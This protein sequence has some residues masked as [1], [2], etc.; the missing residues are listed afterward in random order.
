M[1]KKLLVSMALEGKFADS[2]L[3][4]LDEGDDILTSL[5]RELVMNRRVGESAEAIWRDLRAQSAILHRAHD[6]EPAAEAIPLTLPEVGPISEPA[7]EQTITALRK[8]P[9]SPS[10]A[11][12][13]T[14]F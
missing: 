6:P 2:E 10:P 11:E 8:R 1:G 4:S 14:L 12:Q 7:F 3:Q 5:A 9:S 13:L